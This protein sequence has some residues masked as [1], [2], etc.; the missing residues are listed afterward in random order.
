MRKSRLLAALA[1]CVLAIG[2]IG[3]FG[4]AQQPG[5]PAMRPTVR[6]GPTIALLD[7][8]YIFKNHTRFKAMM[9]DMKADVERAELQMK[10]DRDAIQK[11]AEQMKEYRK[12]TPEYKELA[13]VIT[14]RQADLSIKIR[15][16]KDEFLQRE[17]KTYY[18]V[19]QEIHQEVDYYAAANGITMVLRFNGDPA[20]L[21]RP[22]T[23]IRTI[24]KQVV[25]YTK[26]QDV[27]P[28][29]LDRLNQRAFNPSSTAPHGPA[30]RPGQ[31]VS[32]N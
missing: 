17:A 2:L 26:D 15:L 25:W 11:L 7:V 29:I 23:V 18:N 21:G 22:E 30:R 5:R 16:Q 31:G 12:G 13:E 10:A 28:V 4:V 20:D 9:N 6:G 32:F 3:G 24:N 1:A 19:Y 27:T 14:K 8:P